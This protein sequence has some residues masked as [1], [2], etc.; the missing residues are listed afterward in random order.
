MLLQRATPSEVEASN[1]QSRRPLVDVRAG[2]ATNFHCYV[3]F[4]GI[5][6]KKKNPTKI[7]NLKIHIFTVQKTNHENYKYKKKI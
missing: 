4:V 7:R 5:Q 2:P 3:I 6:K 1:Q